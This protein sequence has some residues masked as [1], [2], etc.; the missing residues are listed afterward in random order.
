VAK[1][2]KS[3]EWANMTNR[4]FPEKKVEW[5]TYIILLLATVLSG[6]V[7]FQH[8]AVIKVQGEISTMPK[9]YVQKDQYNTDNTRTEKKLDKID[10]KLDKLI[11]RLIP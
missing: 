2:G 1:P 6:F 11:E 8:Q 5:L 4:S 3:R 10:T 7:A 9:E